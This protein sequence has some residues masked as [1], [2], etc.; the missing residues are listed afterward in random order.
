MTGFAMLVSLFI[1]ILV[2]TLLTSAGH[3][4]QHID[5]NKF[6]TWHSAL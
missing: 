2:S 6:K 4:R 3:Q 5:V 1:G